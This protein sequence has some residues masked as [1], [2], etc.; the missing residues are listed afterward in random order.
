M[1]FLP[2]KQTIIDWLV[3]YGAFAIFFLLALGIL[4]AP[5]P[6]ETVMV[7]SGL[8]I[9]KGKLAFITT[10]IAAFAGSI[11]G[12]T[13]SYLL[14]RLAGDYLIKRHGNWFGLTEERIQHI[15]NWFEKYGKWTLTFGYFV[16]GVRHFTGFVAGMAE[17]SYHHFALFAYSG[18][19]I[20][21]S[22]FISIGYF[23]GEYWLKL[24]KNFHLDLDEIAYIL[25]AF[26][27]I[28]W[29]IKLIVTRKKTENNS[30]NKG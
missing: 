26:V 19:L 5:I 20:W 30:V 28:A 24:I 6:D 15:H 13:V 8:L 29:V 9:Y 16:P 21:V 27:L 23:L 10:V 17:L 18:A 1:D 14:G 22:T 25:V 2:E 11:C 4:V 12:I 7:V 3:Q